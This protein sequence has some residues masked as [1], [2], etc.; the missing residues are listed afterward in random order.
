MKFSNYLVLIFALSTTFR[1]F[2]HEAQ[3]PEEIFT[4]IYNN[5]VWGIDVH[6]EG[7]SGPGSTVQ[8]TREY[9]R[10]LQQF[11][12]DKTI[13]SVVDLGCGDWQF[14]RHI[15]WSNIHYQG[16]DVVKSVVEK[17]QRKFGAPNIHF[18]HA[19]GTGSALPEADLLICKDV[20]QHLTEMD[21]LRI[22]AQFPKFKYCLITNGVD[23]S[24]LSSS[25]PAIE[26]GGYRPL[27]ITQPPYNITAKKVLNYPA[28][29]FINQV[30]LIERS[31]S[32]S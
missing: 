13:T 30:L 20:L 28:G 3:T 10:F 9:V 4:N 25:N 7:T 26:R 17:N 14:S 8:N 18:C 29:G 1:L 19:D 22:T 12:K 31:E 2:S 32:S 5:A 21:I 11:L 23:P 16:L 24:T 15:D 6:G 27:D